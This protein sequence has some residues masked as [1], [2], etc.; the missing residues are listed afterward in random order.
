MATGLPVDARVPHPPLPPRQHQVLQLLLVEG[1]SEKEAARALGI[2]PHTVHVYVKCLYRRFGVH[3]RS[4]LHAAFCGGW[5]TARPVD[6]DDP[7]RHWYTIAVA[8]VRLLSSPRVI[9]SLGLDRR[10]VH[11]RFGLAS[12]PC[13]R[14]SSSHVCSV[15]GCLARFAAH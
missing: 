1:L 5:G 11:C 9:R 13:H 15:S 2:S 14:A 6:D 4:E 7:V 12:G 3:S 8:C 10:Q